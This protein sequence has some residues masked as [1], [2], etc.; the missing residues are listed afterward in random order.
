MKIR[1]VL[2]PTLLASADVI[3][4]LKASLVH[5]SC[6]ASAAPP[7]SFVGV[8]PCCTVPMCF[9]LLLHWSVLN[10]WCC[11]SRLVLRSG[12]LAA[13][14]FFGGCFA[15]V[16]AWVDTLLPPSLWSPRSAVC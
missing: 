1:P 6:H 4:F 13:V 10:V 16:A 8:A 15:V 5:F 3:S 14:A 7:A 2:L 12:Y 9:N 11:R